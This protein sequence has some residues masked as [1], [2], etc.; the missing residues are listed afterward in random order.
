VLQQA[1]VDHLRP[2]RPSSTF[3]DVTLGEAGHAAAMLERYPDI[4]LLGSD[5]DAALLARSR[6]RLGPYGGRFRLRH[7]W[8]DEA[9]GEMAPG[10]V[11]LMLMD[12]G[13]SRFHIERGAR[14]FSFMRD[15]PLDMR[16]DPRQGVSAADL[17]NRGS[18]AD[19]R[20][21]LTRYGDDR[22][23]RANALA[24]EHARSRHRIETTYQLVRA[25]LARTPWRGGS[26]H[27]ATQVF[28]ALRVAVNDEVGRLRRSLDAA[29]RALRPAGRLAVIAFHSIDDG[30]VK[31]YPA[32]NPHMI[33]L[34]KRPEVPNDAEVR[35]NP[36]SRSARLRVLERLP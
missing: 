2:S 16:F 34:T 19:L 28:Q 1:V 31:R 12:L 15:E 11:D 7:A 24:I 18:P 20:D 33:A 30:I 17:V 22:N 29:A 6:D 9:L 8:S 27:P 35:A 21:L 23:A 32:G 25:I 36:A 3:V 26:R 13:M 5:A 4:T 14:G 10:T